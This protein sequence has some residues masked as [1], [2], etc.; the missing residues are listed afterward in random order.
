MMKKFDHERAEAPVLGTLLMVGLAVAFIAVAGIYVFSI[1]VWEES[2]KQAY[3]KIEPVKT[4]DSQYY[5]KVFNVA[6]DDILVRTGDEAEIKVTDPNGQMH[7][8][9]KGNCLTDFRTGDTAYLFYHKI[10]ENFTLSAKNPES[11]NVSGLAQGKWIF[12]LI[13]TEK[14]ITICRNSVEI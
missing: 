11:G 9:A 4:E 1:P 7:T 12:I 13:D 5:F 6:G 3:F 10:K 8:V 2:P 14:D